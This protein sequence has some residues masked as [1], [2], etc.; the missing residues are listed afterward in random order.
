MTVSVETLEGLERKV[1]VSVPTTKIEE[2][3]NARL[4]DIAGR[5]KMDGFRPGKAPL[6]LVK[7]RYAHDV[8]LDVIREM[9]QPSLYEA[10]KEHDL[11]PVA[12]PR[13]EPGPIE[14]DQDFSY[15]AYFEV[16]PKFE[17]NALGEAQ[18]EFISSEVTDADVDATI[19]KLREQHKTWNDVTR[20]AALGDKLVIDFDVF[21]GDQ[22]L[23][24]RGHGRDFEIILG[25]GAVLPE[26]E[27]SL[28]GVKKDELSEHT[29]DFPADW[30]DVAF[31]G[32]TLC[33]K[34]TVHQIMEGVL[35]PLD[36]ELAEKFNIKAGGLEALKKDIRSH[37]ERA[38]ER[39]VNELNRQTTFDE[40]L[41]RNPFDLPMALL[42]EEIQ[43]LRHEFYHQ[44]FGHHH[45]DDEKIPNFPRHLFEERAT[46]R[47]HLGLLFSDY[48]KQN[49][50]TA[51][52]ERV[53]AMINKSAES[54]DDPDEVR[55]W[56]HND[57]KHMAE[58]EALVIEEKAAE[59]LIE[60]A[61]IT[62]KTMA[63][64]E[65][66]NPPKANQNDKGESA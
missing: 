43:H 33:F 35:P 36:D 17:I 55:A 60:N 27:A 20:A 57:L 22:E 54:Y 19:E 37:M 7:Q 16:F 14:K 31:A 61:I 38:L 1:N 30:H 56:Y 28:V 65:V 45:S 39:R 62:T 11:S 15:A 5:A 41:K 2:E 18:L 66:M 64:G 48:V 40:F 46:R 32:K 29:V 25:A 10:L 26:L 49:E 34:V 44:V 4:K 59:K 8:R 53:E 50:I 47:V 9:L 24:E 63:Y 3:V 23:G 58:I 52:Q 6:N 21:E 12:A 42:D 51:D 13:I